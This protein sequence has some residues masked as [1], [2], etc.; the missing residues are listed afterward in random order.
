MDRSEVTGAAARRFVE[1]VMNGADP[2]VADDLL[3]SAHVMHDPLGNDLPPGPDGARLWAAGMRTAFP[4]LVYRIDGVI[5]EPSRAAVRLMGGGTHRGVLLE[6]APSGHSFMARA[7]CWF[8]FEDGRIAETWVV[9]DSLS[10]ALHL[11]VV[12]RVGPW[13][14]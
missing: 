11:G 7:V 9:P 5:T 12:E 1:C 3:T 14:G 10:A 13:A 6:G 2:S 8:H 4:D